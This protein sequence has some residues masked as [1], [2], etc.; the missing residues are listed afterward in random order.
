MRDT[1]C[2]NWNSACEFNIADALDPDGDIPAE[3]E[4]VAA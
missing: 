4:P 3:S 1:I 2:E